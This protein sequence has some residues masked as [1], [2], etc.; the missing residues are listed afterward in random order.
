MKVETKEQAWKEANKIFPTDYEKDFD[1]SERAGYDVY[2]HRELNPL[3]RICDLGCRLEVI[4]DNN[5]INIWIDEPEKM[6]LK[7]FLKM[8]KE[9]VQVVV[10]QK[11]NCFKYACLSTSFH[12][13]EAMDRK[14]YEVSSVVTFSSDAKISVTVW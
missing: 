7:D 13:E 8:L 6:K 14:V 4:I 10:K 1:A 12:A 11:G 9:P 5:V 3:N 2:R